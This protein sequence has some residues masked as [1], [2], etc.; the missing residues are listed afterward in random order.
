MSAPK[1]SVICPVYKAEA[2]LSRCVDSVLS[3][4]FKDFELL[5]IDDGSPDNSGNICDEYVKK[6]N[7]VKAFH[8]ENRGV[9]EARQLGL[10]RAIGKYVAFIDADDWVEKDFL[11]TLFDVAEKGHYDVV[12]CN[13]YQTENNEDK[14]I[15]V[16]YKN[17]S[18]FDEMIKG[19]RNTFLWN[20]LFLKKTLNVAGCRF[21]TGLH[22]CEDKMFLLDLYAV[23]KIRECLVDKRLYHY[24]QYGNDSSLSRTITPQTI[25]QR[26]RFAGIV[27]K[28]YASNPNAKKLYSNVISAAICL[29]FANG[30]YIED[31]KQRFYPYRFL[32][33]RG[34]SNLLT[35]T[36]SYLSC[37]GKIYMRLN[38][39]YRTLKNL[40]RR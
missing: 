2:F 29:A 20:K 13:Y 15:V 8:Q 30:L 11:N 37:Y 5:L 14:P 25:E 1:I 9:S 12:E 3:Q 7:R 16:V 6:D 38:K 24:M 21:I 4:T 22:Y 10:D 17:S 35:R 23:K 36:F 31:F 34:D 19:E 26:F 18:S 33:L 28:T 27:H 40:T 39:L 32:I